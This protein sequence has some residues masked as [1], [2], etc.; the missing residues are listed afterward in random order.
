MIF[1]SFEIRR[2]LYE[3]F[4]DVV[5]IGSGPGG[6]SCCYQLSLSGKKIILLEEGWNHPYTLHGKD[7]LTS[8]IK[9]YRYSG[10]FTSL[11]SPPVPILMGRT[12][13]GAS[14]INQACA[15]RLPERVKKKWREEGLS[16]FMNKIDY[17]FKDIEDFLGVKPVAEYNLNRNGEIF[18]SAIN[19]MGGKAE[20]MPR[21]A[22]DCSMCGTC[23]MGCPTLEK[24]STDVSFIKT[25]SDNGAIIICGARAMKIV[26]NKKGVHVEGFILGPEG[27]R[28]SHFSIFSKVVVI[29][30][31]AIFTP[32]LLK[33]SRISHPFDRIGKNLFLHPTS[34]VVGIHPEPV[35]GYVGIP[36][37]AYS[38]SFFNETGCILESMFIPPLT[39][40]SALPGTPK[41]H[42]ERMKK[43]NY[44]SMAIIQR[45]DSS[46]GR[47]IF[48]KDNPVPIYSLSEEDGREL[49]RGTKIMIEGLLNAGAEEVLVF[50]TEKDSFK[51]I[52]EVRKCSLSFSRSLGFIYS[53]HPQG[54]CCAGADPEKYPVDPYLCLRGS[55]KIYIADTS[56]FPT[57]ATV[58]PMLTAMAA[59][60]FAAETILKRHF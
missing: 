49:G 9:F 38:H 23:I 33:L 24:K 43:Y 39:L 59:G 25:A 2:P 42:I 15:L 22:P 28:I 60:Y 30:C 12:L 53:A 6:A 48:T 45:A 46:G 11:G 5:I 14:R 1:N 37:Q 18:I 58:N 29:S 47:V 36:M 17:Y 4:A 7:E 35:E 3:S 27:E 55:E 21:N 8:F 13:G 16:E 56:I 10:L 52:K 54:S 26:E 44:F 20:L 57:P 50:H 34:L 32:Y 19:S 41:E 40:S 51:N 31:G